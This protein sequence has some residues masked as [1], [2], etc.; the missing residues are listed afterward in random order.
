MA[1]GG[2][3]YVLIDSHR[4]ESH[5]TTLQKPNVITELFRFYV[6]LQEFGQCHSD[7]FC[8]VAVFSGML[9]HANTVWGVN[10]DVSSWYV[11]TPVFSDVCC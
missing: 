2:V 6:G 10:S 7:E 4:L 3:K 5:R 1:T 11:N 9:K 8:S